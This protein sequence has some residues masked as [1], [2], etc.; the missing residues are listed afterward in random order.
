ME[1][2][3]DNKASLWLDKSHFNHEQQG[4]LRLSPVLQPPM[5]SCRLIGR[6]VR[7]KGALAILIVNAHVL[8]WLPVYLYP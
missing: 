5:H 4:L 1:G 3:Q 8:Q 7:H 2:H 6:T